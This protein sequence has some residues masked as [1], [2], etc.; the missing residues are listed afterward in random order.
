MNSRSQTIPRPLVRLN[1]WTIVTAVLLTWLTSWHYFLLVPLL[2]GISGLLF[3]LHPV[4]YIGKK[5]L[6]KPLPSYIP[7][8]KQQQQFNQIIAVFCLTMAYMAYTG[9][10][11]IIGHLFTAMVFLAASIAIM[12]FC[13]GCFIRFQ[14]QQYRYRKLHSGR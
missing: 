7:E 1:Q 9:G 8:D 14:W 4:L 3:D 2:A 13:V 11:M 6:K 10:W 5:F 12:G